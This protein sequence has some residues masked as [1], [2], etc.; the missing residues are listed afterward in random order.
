MKI[1]ILSI[2]A[3]TMSC[4]AR[5][6]FCISKMTPKNGVNLKLSKINWRNFEKS[7]RLAQIN[8]VSTVMITSKGEATLYPKQITEYLNKLK[9]YDFPIIE[10][11]TNGII[12]D[13]K[14]EDYENHLKEWYDLGLTT[15]AISIVHYDPSK[16]KS[17][18]LPYKENYIDLQRVIKRLHDIGFVVRLACIM[19]KGFI[20]SDKKVEKLIKFAK[21]NNVEQLTLRPVNKPDNSES[22]EKENWTQNHYLDNKTKEEIEKYV[23]E[24]GNKIRSLN[25]G[26]N[27][28]DIDGQNVC[29]TN[30]LTIDKESED[31]RQ[32]IFYSDGKLMYDWQFKGAR[33]I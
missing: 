22:Y 3:G 30:S 17:V 19:A 7:C 2:V 5:C 31:I 20:D 28:F 11:Q 23:L 25:S 6:P 8:N 14:W 24:N 21:E 18:Y 12:F 26:G 15:I 1:D 4:N 13:E 33:L 29:I 9:Q 32:L 10:L 27:I 16:N